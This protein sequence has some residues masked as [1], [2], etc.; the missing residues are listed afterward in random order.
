M[1]RRTMAVS[2]AAG[3]TS[4]FC[5]CWSRSRPVE[6]W[7]IMS[8]VNKRNGFTLVELLVV[9]GII[10]LLISILM[11]ALARARGEAQM[12]ACTARIRQLAMA[13]IMYANENKGYL[14]PVSS[15]GIPGAAYATTTIVWPVW[16][17]NG[18]ITQY[19]TDRPL[20]NSMQG[21]GEMFTCPSQVDNSQF[22]PTGL[23]WSYRY[24]RQLGGDDSQ[25]ETQIGTTT[26]Y[27]F[28]PWKITQISDPSHMCLLTE[29]PLQINTP[30]TAA[31]LT[32]TFDGG[33]E[34]HAAGQNY[35]SASYY[36]IVHF[37]KIP[38]YTFS[39][40]P[41]GA[42]PVTSGYNNVAFCDG[43]ARSINVTYNKY[44]YPAWED[45][46]FDPYHPVQ[47]W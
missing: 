1:T 45:V 26:S 20:K 46:L 16:G 27:N 14:P 6:K 11:P 30:P 29:G 13:S 40:T 12:V 42:Q 19:L 38:G 17:S 4:I 32:I 3:G 28:V 34:G 5:S 35:Q 8:K 37:Q 7:C 9:I 22:S 41:W 24:H 21:I 36:G 31:N 25:R 43:S 44:P 47:Q 39:G 23:C 33:S 2:V 10:A 18:Y 15:S